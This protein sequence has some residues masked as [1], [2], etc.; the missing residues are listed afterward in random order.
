T[1]APPFKLAFTRGKKE[2]LAFVASLQAEGY[3]VAGTIQPA[4]KMPYTL[5][6]FISGV[7]ANW[8]ATVV[9]ENG[10]MDDF[11]VFE[12]I[13]RARLD[14]TK[15]GTFYAGNIITAGDPH[16]GLSITRWDANGIT[17]DLNNPT[18][19]PI[20]TLISTPREINGKYRLQQ[21]ITIPAGSSRQQEFSAGKKTVKRSAAD[22]LQRLYVKR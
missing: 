6:L 13:G 18:D 4:D 21:Q 7:N 10:T 1:D 20:T 14:V 19:T 22:F 12:G 8:D 3:G 17:V 2:G 9:R 16:L 11:G 5:P 15:G